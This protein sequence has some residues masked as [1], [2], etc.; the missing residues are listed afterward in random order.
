M[1]NHIGSADSREGLAHKRYLLAAACAGI[2]ASVFLT[3]V[4]ASAGDGT[5][6]N[7][8]ANGERIELGKLHCIKAASGKEFLARC[9]RV[10][11]NTSWKRLQEGCP[12]VVNWSPMPDKPLS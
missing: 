10:L 6:C 1:Q 5:D 7:C 4:P 2:V 12:S 3:A 9:E 8:V 11:N